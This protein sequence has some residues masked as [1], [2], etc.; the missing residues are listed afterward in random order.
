METEQKQSLQSVPSNKKRQ[1]IH[2]KDLQS[3]NHRASLAYYGSARQKR[4]HHSQA[5]WRLKFLNFFAY[6]GLNIFSRAIV[7]SI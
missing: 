1:E 4:D 6:F 7:Y 3:F 5:G 2:D